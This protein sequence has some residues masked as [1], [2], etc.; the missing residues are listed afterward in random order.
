MYKEII[1]NNYPTHAIVY[2]SGVRTD[3]KKVNGQTL[4]SGLNGFKRREMILY[5]KQEL[6][7][8]VPASFILKNFPVKASLDWYIVPNYET[9]KWSNKKQEITGGKVIKDKMY[10]PSFDVDNQWIWTKVFTDVISKELKIVPE[11]TVKY[12][13]INGQIKYIP[14]DN[15]EDRKLVFKFEA[16]EDFDPEYLKLLKKYHKYD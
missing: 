8:Q 13:P 15:I 12:I 7:K 14:I 5:L 4:Y 6:K 16:I 2:Q 3:Y 10:E 9:V 1:I 11:D